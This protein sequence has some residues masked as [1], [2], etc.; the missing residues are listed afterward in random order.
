MRRSLAA[1]ILAFVMA[2]I[3]IVL[4]IGGIYLVSL[5]GSA[6]YVSPES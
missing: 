6:Y 4:T 5:G 3:G 1:M 2:L